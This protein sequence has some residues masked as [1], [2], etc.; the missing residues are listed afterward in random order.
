MISGWEKEAVE[1]LK[2]AMQRT[3]ER[4]EGLLN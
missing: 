4:N 2:T 1:E 3:I